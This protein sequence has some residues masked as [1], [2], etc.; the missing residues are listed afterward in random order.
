MLPGHDQQ[1]RVRG[2]YAPG[3][4]LGALNLSKGTQQAS[5]SSAR[6]ALTRDHQISCALR[7]SLRAE[8]VEGHPADFDKLSPHST[9]KRLT[10]RLVP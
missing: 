5:T 6:I 7:L 4:C 9:P 10:T 1:M 3:A 2:L 8:L